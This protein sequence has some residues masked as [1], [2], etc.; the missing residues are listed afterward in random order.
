MLAFVFFLKLSE[1]AKIAFKPEML[2]L[3]SNF[4]T[5][6]SNFSS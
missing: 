1:Q 2:S 5:K 4:T 3:P 6:K